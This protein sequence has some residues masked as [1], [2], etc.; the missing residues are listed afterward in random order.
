MLA[1]PSPTSP[2]VRPSPGPGRHRRNS[3]VALLVAYSAPTD[4]PHG[5]GT[6]PGPHHPS[7][8]CWSA[9]R[10]RG[11]LPDARHPCMTASVILPRTIPN[12]PVSPGNLTPGR[13]HQA[14]PESSSCRRRQRALWG[15]TAGPKKS[16]QAGH[17]LLAVGANAPTHTLGFGG[18][19]PQSGPP[20]SEAGLPLTRVQS[21]LPRIRA[22]PSLVGQRPP[23]RLRAPGAGNGPAWRR[24]LASAAGPSQMP[25][26]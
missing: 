25:P 17:S 20:F 4:N 26:R 19:L 11:R 10:L 6:S 15:G 24:G 5:S 2:L 8:G 13:W 23:G 18:P 21:P 9:Y 1:Q 3:L 12:A 7:P 16:L 14:F 22:T